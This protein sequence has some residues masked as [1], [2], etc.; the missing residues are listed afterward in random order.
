[1][2]KI[3]KPISK[4]QRDQILN[5]LYLTPN[6]IYLLINGISYLKAVEIAKNMCKKMEEKKMYDPSKPENWDGKTRRR[7]LVNTELFRKEMKI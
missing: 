5:Q 2:E 4:E 6:Q 7:Y 3:E 1:M